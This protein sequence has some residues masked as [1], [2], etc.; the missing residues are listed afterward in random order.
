L[1]PFNAL[2]VI[3]LLPLEPCVIVKLLGEADKEKSG[4]LG[5]G[6]LE[7]GQFFTRLAALTVPMPVAKS[8]PTFVPKAGLDELFD[9][10][11]TPSKPEGK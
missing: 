5:G 2:T 9:V 11:S 4:W 8:Q 10:E 7:P 1:K 6:A 3:L